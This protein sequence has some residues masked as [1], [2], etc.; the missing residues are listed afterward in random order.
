[1]S[2]DTAAFATKVEH[3]QVILARAKAAGDF[4]AVEGMAADLVLLVA[5]AQVFL[6]ETFAAA[7]IDHEKRLIAIEAG[8]Q[9]AA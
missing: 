9:G 8:L 4:R 6:A 2:F 3:L 1:M 7:L 5:E